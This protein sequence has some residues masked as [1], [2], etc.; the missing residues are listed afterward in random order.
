MATKTI[1]PGEFDTKV[2]IQ[3]V[4]AGRGTQGQRTVSYVDHSTPFA[5]IERGVDET[6]Q[7]G[8]LEASQNLT[9]TGYKI[10]A[11]TTRWRVLVDSK[12]YEVRSIDPI[13]RM[14]PYFILTLHAIDG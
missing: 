6:V 7:D 5:K 1:N 3:S 8:N 12:P 9:L 10:A 13:D 11:M 14:S 2:K 4:T